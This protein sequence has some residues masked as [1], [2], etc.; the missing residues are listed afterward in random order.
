[1]RSPTLPHHLLVYD[2]AALVGLPRP[3]MEYRFLA[4]RKYRFDFAWSE[5]KIALEIEGGIYSRGRHVRPK[6]HLADIEKDNLAASEGW[7]VFRAAPNSLAD[8]TNHNTANQAFFQKI[9]HQYEQR[10]RA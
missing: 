6:G 7:L 3:E 9:K 10:S 5:A 8:K 2:T 4:N 1:M